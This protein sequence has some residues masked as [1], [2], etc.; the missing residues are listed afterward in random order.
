MSDSAILR[1]L[2]KRYLEFCNSD[3]NAEKRDLWRRHNSL[4]PTRPLLLAMTRTHFDTAP[5]SRCVVGDEFLRLFERVLRWR[6]YQAECGDDTVFEPFLVHS[7][8]MIFPVEGAERWG[9][10][11]R[12]ISAGERKGW[13]I[14]PPLKTLED[15]DRLV[16]PPHRVDEEDSERGRAK[17]QEALG[18]VLPVVLDRGPIL[19]EYP[20]DLSTDVAFLRG[21]EQIMWDMTDNPEWLHR[22]MG[23]LRDGELNNHE[24]CEHAGD[25]R[26]LNSNN[27]SMPYCRE[28]PGPSASTEPVERKDLWWFMAAQEFALIS[29]QMHEEFLLRYQ[30]PVLEKFGLTAYGC[31]EDLTGK[32]D[33][34]RKIPNLRRIS[35]TPWAD[36]AGCAEQIG[37]DYVVSWRPNPATTVCVGFDED[38]IRTDTREAFGAFR[39]HGCVMD[40]TLKDVQ[41]VEGEAWRVKE[42]CRIVR[43]CAEEY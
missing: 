25:F 18:D 13:L 17:L 14:D 8:T 6:I 34:L 21:L 3:E 2:A 33:I 37:T 43:E 1:N 29:P 12:R 36:V 4:E 27:Q 32:I 20:G 19:R 39:R 22:L 35:I 41:T 11:W 26:A 15:I 5:E 9:V 10:E 38:R 40:V 42:W 7:A 30:I 31:C 24:Q 28:L 16:Q 23:F